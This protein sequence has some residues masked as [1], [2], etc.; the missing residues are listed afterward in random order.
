MRTPNHFMMFITAA[1]GLFAL[2]GACRGQLPPTQPPRLQQDSPATS[3]NDAP[4]GPMAIDPLGSGGTNILPN[5]GPS[6]SPPTG[7]SG[8]TH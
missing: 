1:A 5:P 4:T 8:P 2:V 3:T 6:P 7:G